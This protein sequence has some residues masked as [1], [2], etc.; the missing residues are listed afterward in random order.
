MRKKYLPIGSI[1]ALKNMDLKIMIVGFFV[2]KEEDNNK[3]FDY[4][5]CVYPQGFFSTDGYILFDHEDIEKIY[6]V[7][8]QDEENTKYHEYL[9]E[10]NKEE[11]KENNNENLE[12]EQQ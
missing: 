6:F 4:N 10:I 11:I 3:V 12:S 1:V 9:K 2:T 7:G 8:Y 5:G